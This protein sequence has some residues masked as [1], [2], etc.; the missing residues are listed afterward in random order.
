MELLATILIL[1]LV[2]A[3]SGVIVRFVSFPAPLLQT[4][5][6]ALLALLFHLNI[7]LDPA[8]FLCLF[9]APLL[10]V[11][12]FRFPQ[13]EL[14]HLWPTI[15]LLA[16]GL[17]V[18]TVVGAGYFIDRL[19]PVMPLAVSFA[20]AAV[21]APTDAVAVAGSTGNA[22]LPS[23]LMHIL[24]GEALFNDASSL[25]CLRFAVA[26]VMTG[27]FEPGLALLA[28]IIEVGGALVVGIA[29][30]WIAG[31]CQAWVVRKAGEHPPTQILIFLLIPFAAYLAAER[32]HVSGILASV[33]AGVTL[34]FMPRPVGMVG[35]RLQGESVWNMLQF[36]LNGIIFVLLG[37]QLPGILGRAGAIAAEA[38]VDSAWM[39]GL[40]VLAISVALVL[41][42]LV[43]TWATLKL[44]LYR[45]FAK[46]R[47]RLSLPLVIAG[48]VAG[49]RGAITLAAVLSL[50]LTLPNGQPFPARDLAVF[51]AAWVI[52]ISL[53]AAAIVLPLLLHRLPQPA[54]TKAGEE[55]RRAR[56][57]AAAAAIK[58]IEA[59]QESAGNLASEAAEI[60]P[61][62]AMRVIGEYRMRMETAGG[63]E[64]VRQHAAQLNRAERRL[65]Q[66]AI[67]A[68]REEL[69][70]LA[71]TEALNHRSAA[72]LLRRLDIAEAILAEESTR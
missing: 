70:K 33:V 65:R 67:R 27:S 4:A 53:V 35:T 37:L 16:L 24:E 34:N 36:A 66:M 68:E 2:V 10:F 11:D 51:L 71:K 25:V 38:G 31:R 47:K 64:E 50:P 61:E 1:L 19:I 15:L 28:F 22:K 55:E 14:R 20:L 43:W 44:T 9:V 7:A 3:A 58:R 5:F 21:L 6:G 45:G 29:V 17:V 46:D 39:L 57:A 8:L 12:A 63:S 41:L 18:F 62:A 42:R 32:L 13:T 60:V 40:Y 30:G 49:V 54:E 52:L 23:R 72:R 69:T 48:S 59:E 26:A 56:A